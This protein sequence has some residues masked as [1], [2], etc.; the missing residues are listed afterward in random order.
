MCYSSL[1][2]RKNK[3]GAKRV[4]HLKK[5]KKLIFYLAFFLRTLFALKYIYR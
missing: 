2:K 3:E 4:T 1:N 5:N